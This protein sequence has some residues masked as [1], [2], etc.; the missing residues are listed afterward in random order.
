MIIDGSNA[1][2]G[3]LA[4]Y[5][6]KRL[7]EGESV[8][9]TN[10]EKIVISGS[11]EHVTSVYKNRRGMTQKA[12]PEHG[13]KWPRRPDLLFKRI[14]EGMLP[15]HSNRKTMAMRALRVYLGTPA[16]LKETSM[17]PVKTSEKLARNFVSLEK[18]C[19]NLGWVAK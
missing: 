1:V 5:A 18:L 11:E 2:A 6:A 14:I 13:M 3:R 19:A 12:N 17:K 9:I 10:A 16:D 4:A 7:L 15:K 8:V